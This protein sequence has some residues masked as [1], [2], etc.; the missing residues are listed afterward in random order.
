MG[1]HGLSLKELVLLGRRAERECARCFRALASHIAPTNQSIVRVVLDHA[2][3]EEAHDAALEGFDKRLKWPSVWH[4]DEGMIDR[5]LRENLPCLCHDDAAGSLDEAAAVE[6]TREIEDE[7][8]RFYR[9]LARH[10][11]DEESRAFFVSLAD[12]EISHRSVIPAGLPPEAPA[13][14]PG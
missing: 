6:R 1:L 9:A 3:E 13:S 14:S 8:I 4:L 5:L 12:W 10:A 2:A 11:P 7:A